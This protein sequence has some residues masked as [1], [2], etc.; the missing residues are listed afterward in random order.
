[1]SGV[2][3]RDLKNNIETVKYSVLEEKLHNTN[4]GSYYD[5]I[6]DYFINQ[7]NG[8][9]KISFPT[10]K[11]FTEICP[12]YY[13]DLIELYGQ[14][15]SQMDISCV[16]VDTM[17]S[18][19]A[20][21]DGLCFIYDSVKDKYE[22]ATMNF[23]LLY[24]FQIEYDMLKQV[25]TKN[26]NGLIKA[27]RIDVEYI[28]G[29]EEFNFKAVN[30]RDFG[31][32]DDNKPDGSEDKR[33]YII[34]YYFC[35]ELMNLIN[36]KLDKG[37]T[38]RIHQALDGVEKVRFISKDLSVLSNMCDIPVAVADVDAKYFPLC[39]FF[40]APVVG[41]PSTTA[42][43]TNISV[44][45]IYMIKNVKETD[46]KRFNVAKCDNPIR[47]LIAE[48]LVSRTLIDLKYFDISDFSFI[49]DKLPYR[50]KFL[51]NDVATI[52]EISISKYLH[53]ITNTARKKIYNLLNL[54][55]EINKRM[56]VINGGRKM[57]D[58]DIVNIDKLLQGSVCKIVV[59]KKNCKLSS[60]ICTN[61]YSILEYVYGDDYVRKF[62]GFSTKYYKF[63][64]CIKS[65]TLDENDMVHSREKL[66]GI[67]T[68]CGLPDDEPD[69]DAVIGA[70]RKAGNDINNEI[71][72]LL[73]EYFSD[74]VGVSYKRSISQSENNSNSKSK[75]TVLARSLFAYI[76]ED[77]KPVDFY[78]Y[79][80]RSKILS[81][82]VF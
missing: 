36:L 12:E 7:L 14:K 23:E 77:G 59:M 42:M 1:M 44:F 73:K 28:N 75:G 24:D 48:R 10:L 61:N 31:Y 8:N 40:Y 82:I 45:D 63:L 26:N 50:N 6:A 15:M 52:D 5:K 43:V 78:K 9:G 81:G 29:S 27:Y 70:V 55:E 62:E 17:V 4:I 49:I 67:L 32:I 79:I 2:L 33:F 60:I 46:Y 68:M 51:A 47:D 34:P 76:D 54:D 74:I 35:Y 37:E 20:L 69:L 66:K 18:Q 71:Y 56:S 11:K 39:G 38:L 80:D 19:A 57:T 13:S 53:S 3:L 64:S 72:E 65:Y 16:D 58:E 21:F 30:A 25:L 22:L 41:A